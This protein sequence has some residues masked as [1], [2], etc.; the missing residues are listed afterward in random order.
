MKNEWKSVGKLITVQDA[1]WRDGFM[2][3]I[4]NGNV[5]DP[6]KQEFMIFKNDNSEIDA[7]YIIIARDLKIKALKAKKIDAETNDLITNNLI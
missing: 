6:V 3:R 4:F 2:L 1:K 5:F 7:N